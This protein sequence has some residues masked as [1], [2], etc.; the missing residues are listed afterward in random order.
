MT[1]GWR[2]KYEARIKSAQ[3]R[4]MRRDLIRWRGTKCERCGRIATL[5]LHHKTYERLGREL[6]SDLELLCHSCHEAADEERA[7]AGR[8]RSVNARAAAMYDA[9][10][11]TYATKKYGD[12]WQWSR[13]GG[14]I[15]DIEEE[16]DR[17][18]ERK[19]HGLVI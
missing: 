18:L 12:D 4:N 9:G 5:E 7:E 2:Q 13:W 6:T 10:L 15:D 11:D 14:D 19:K 17:W 8:A 3:W 16:Y 1:D